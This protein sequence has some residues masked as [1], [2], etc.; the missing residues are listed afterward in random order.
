MRRAQCRAREAGRHE[1]HSLD[2]LARLL[3]PYQRDGGATIDPRQG[4]NVQETVDV[5]E[6][7]RRLGFAEIAFAGTMEND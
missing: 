1:A 2:E 6:R 3:R 5:M 7:M 4:V